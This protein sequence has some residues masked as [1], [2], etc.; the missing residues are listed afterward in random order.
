MSLVSWLCESR[1]QQGK[2][3]T[4]K[5]I[6]VHSHNHRWHGKAIIITYSEGMSVALSFPALKV[7]APYIVISGMSGCTIFFH[8]I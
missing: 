4:Y 2:Q 3:R 7:H 6:G 5:Y 1:I 8:I